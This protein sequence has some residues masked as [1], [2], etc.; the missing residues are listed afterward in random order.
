MSCTPLGKVAASLLCVLLVSCSATRHISPSSPEELARLVLVIKE[1][2][3]GT[4]THSWRR[5]EEFDLSQYSFLASVNRATR[6][7]VTVAAGWNRDCDEENRECIRECMS[8]PLPRGFGHVTSNGTRGGK[9]SYCSD[10]CWQPYR[11]CQELER[12]RPQEFTAIEPALDWLK[13]HHKEVLVGS[14]I[15][16]AG[17]AFIVISAGAGVITLA[18]ALLFAGPGTGTEPVMAQGTP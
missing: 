3:D 2:P 5:A 7:I 15:V 6:P 11:D 17:V 13:R 1:L 10:R 9:L 12:Q 14:A 16:I 8:R 4:V 18:P